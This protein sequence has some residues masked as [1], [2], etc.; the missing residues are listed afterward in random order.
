M[1]NIVPDKAEAEIALCLAP[2]VPARNAM[3]RVKTLVGEA[4][5]VKI[6][7]ILESDPNL[8]SPQ[9]P[10][11]NILKS[12]S[13]SMM[14]VDPKPFLSTGTSDAHAFRLRGIPTVWFGPGDITGVHG[15]DEYVN[16]KDLTDFAKT[17]FKTA[18]EYCA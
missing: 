5:D 8:T 6:E 7:T 14:N 9:L 13:R 12:A 1:I 11:V 18:V 10:F 17:Y 3:E 2:G 4:A 16:A 15:Y